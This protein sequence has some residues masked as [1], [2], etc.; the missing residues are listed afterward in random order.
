[1]DIKTAIKYYQQ[2]QKAAAAA[3]QA[4]KAAREKERALYRAIPGEVFK[5]GRKETPE[6]KAALQ[7]SEEA[8]KLQ[9]AANIA[10][11]VAIAASD[12]VLNVAHNIILETISAAPEKYTKPL[13]YKVM[14][15]A[16]DGILNHPDFY[17]R[18]SYSTVELY[19]RNAI[20]S[21]SKF[22]FTTNNDNTINFNE[23]HINYRHPE[24]TL[25][26]IRK[27]AKQAAK[28]AAKLRAAAEK[29]KKEADATKEKYTS[30]IKYILPSCNYDVLID[31]YRLF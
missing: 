12:N 20:G 2:A 25:Q 28:D 30:Y 8:A 15:A 27:E 26:Q 18:G 23:N 17:I 13:H 22:L 3:D 29:L 4:T 6:Y 21:R 9:Q 19:F 24:N 5:P 10:R 1:M 31:D 7:A 16:L 11:A 14:Q